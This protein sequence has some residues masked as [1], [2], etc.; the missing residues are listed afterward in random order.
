[1]SNDDVSNDDVYRLPDGCVVSLSDLERGKGCSRC[2]AFVPVR[3]DLPPEPD[4]ADYTRFGMTDYAGTD[5]RV[6]G[7]SVSGFL[8]P[9][10]R[11][12]FYKWL[13]EGA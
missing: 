7:G 13:A 12:D 5:N 1:M 11:N 2:A 10:C 8:C 6:I 3:R 4:E 9:D